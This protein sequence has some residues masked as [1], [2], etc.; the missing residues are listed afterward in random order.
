MGRIWG[1]R[2]A[3]VLSYITVAIDTTTRIMSGTYDGMIM[4]IMSEI[5]KRGKLGSRIA[6]TLGTVSKAPYS[7]ILIARL[8]QIRQLSKRTDS[9]CDSGACRV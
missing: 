2:N 8:N 7:P 9:G 4:V 3:H 6:Q 1:A 5:L